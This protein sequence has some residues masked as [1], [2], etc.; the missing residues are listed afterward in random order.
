M[1]M[2][3]FTVVTCVFVLFQGT[4]NAGLDTN[5]DFDEH[6]FAILRHPDQGPIIITGAMADARLL[7]ATSLLRTMNGAD[8][9]SCCIVLRRIG[10]GEEISLVQPGFHGPEFNNITNDADLTMLLDSE[11]VPPQPLIRVVT[12]AFGVC[13]SAGAILGCARTPGTTMVLVGSTGALQS[14]DV[15]W[16]HEFGHN[17]GLPHRNGPAL[18]MNSSLQTPMDLISQAECDA[19]HDGFTSGTAIGS[20]SAAAVPTLS[21]W[22]TFGLAVL[23]MAA[24]TVAMRRRTANLHLK[25]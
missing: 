1:K 13:G 24:G 19:F 9:I 5:A 2:G 22:G 8:D 20:C 3:I 12:S 14:Q 15:V 4:V 7:G 11:I 25:E 18:I 21:A 6:E 10:V 23:L 17:Q 16:A